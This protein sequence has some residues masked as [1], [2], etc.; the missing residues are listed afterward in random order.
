MDRA[1]WENQHNFALLHQLSAS[2]TTKALL[3]RDAHP[4]FTLPF[5][6]V[7]AG[8][9]VGFGGFLAV[10]Y[11][12]LVKATDRAGWEEY[13]VR[14]QAWIDESLYLEEIHLDHLNPMKGTFQEHYE[15]YEAVR[16]GQP[17]HRDL[18]SLDSKKKNTR[19]RTEIFHWEGDTIVPETE[20]TG[21][22]MFAPLWQVTPASS[23]PVNL[24]LLADPVINHL[25]T[26]MEA[27][28]QTVLSEPVEVH[29]HDLFEFLFLGHEED[30]WR[31]YSYVLNAV[32][33]TFETEDR[34]TVGTSILANFLLYLTFFYRVS[35]RHRFTG[36]FV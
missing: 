12:P 28:N 24:N 21:D 8:Y 2:V 36:E 14:E 19:I 1:Q 3:T 20:Y 4:N 27:I 32:Y 29:D 35:C 33:D 6:E 15:K 26:A 7:T 22:T 31:P 16:E 9:S 10:A 11:A 13:S 5:F 17:K 34:H 23:D 30:R 25:F 18:N